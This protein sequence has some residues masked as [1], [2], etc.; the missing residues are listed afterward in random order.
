MFQ[1]IY[2]I[3]VSGHCLCFIF[4]ISSNCW[5]HEIWICTKFNEFFILIFYRLLNIWPKCEVAGGGG[6]DEAVQDWTCRALGRKQFGGR[7]SDCCC[8]RTSKKEKNYIV[9]STRTSACSTEPW[10]TQPRTSKKRWGEFDSPFVI[11]CP[12]VSSKNNKTK[13]VHRT[14]GKTVMIFIFQYDFKFRY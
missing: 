7:A 5:R 4:K 2:V 9:A 3:S 14:Y 6:R 13:I 1:Q 11:H 8:I 12:T 10:Q